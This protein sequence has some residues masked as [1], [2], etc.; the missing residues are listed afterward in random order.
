VEKNKKRQQKRGPGFLEVLKILEEKALGDKKFFS[1]QSIGMVDIAY[2]WLAYWFSGMEEAVGV[3][4]VNPSALPRLYA[5]IQ[6]FK[7][8]PVIKENLP[9]YGK[10]LAYMKCMRA[11]FISDLPCHNH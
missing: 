6:V 3:E 1:G 10:M 9:D 5:W 4:V 7:E 11:K 8:V 2:G